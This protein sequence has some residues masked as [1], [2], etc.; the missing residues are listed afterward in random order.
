MLD[1]TFLLTSENYLSIA[2]KKIRRNGILTYILNMD[3]SKILILEKMKKE[4]GYSSF[5][6]INPETNKSCN[7]KS[8]ARISS[9]AMVS[10]I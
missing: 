3:E 8:I 7:N 5:S 4:T 2:D 1:P 6:V 9:R 10:R